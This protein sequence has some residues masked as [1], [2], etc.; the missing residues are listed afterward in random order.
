LKWLRL[1]VVLLITPMFASAQLKP[2]LNHILIRG[3]RQDLYFLPA[4]K[5]GV[6][7]KGTILFSPGDGGWRGFAVTMAQHMAAAGYD[8]YGFDVHVYLS[9]FTTSHGALNPTDVMHDYGELIRDLQAS[10]HVPVILAGW[11]E[12]AGLNLLA[13]ST[14]DNAGLIAGILAIGLPTR[15]ILGW[16]TADTLTWITKKFPN[17]PTFASSDYL[18]KISVPFFMIHSRGDEFT[19]LGDAEQMFTLLK[20]PKQLVITNARNH[21]FDGGQDHFFAQLVEGLHWIQAH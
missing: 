6:E 15:S 3:Q 4:T 13:A 17:E 5:N 16:R 2:G 1:A 21:R 19:P 8:T 14:S 9:S 11:S 12:G 10:N 18:G 20:S 7:S